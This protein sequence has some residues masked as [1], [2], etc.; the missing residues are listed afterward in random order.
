MHVKHPLNPIYDSYSKVL[1]LGTMPSIKSREE[2]FYYAHPKNRFWSTLSKVFEES[3]GNTKE[4]KM[5]FLLKHNIALFDVLKSCEISSSSD[6][7]IKNP[8]PNDFTNILKNSN[9]TTIFTT[10]KKAY[11]LYQKYCYSKTG[12]EAICLPSP[13]PANCPKGIEE[14]LFQ[15]YR[16]IREIV[17]ERD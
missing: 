13:S 3:I 5:A 12:I 17:S 7:S 8:I 4:E 1:I 6:S 10:G 2:N 15:E 9:I 11:Q 16:R 14:K